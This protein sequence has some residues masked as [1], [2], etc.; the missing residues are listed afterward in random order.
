VGGKAQDPLLRLSIATEVLLS[1]D[2]IA[3]NEN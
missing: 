3:T 1:R 2:P